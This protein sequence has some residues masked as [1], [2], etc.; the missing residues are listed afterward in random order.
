MDE[1]RLVDLAARRHMVLSLAELRELG[2]GVNGVSRRTGSGRLRRLHRGVYA[3][4]PGPLTERGRWRAA[5]LASSPGAVLSHDD[6]G[7]LWGVLRSR[8]GRAH[9]S[10]ARVGPKDVRGVVLHR[11]SRLDEL[12]VTERDGIPVTSPART[13]V[14]LAG[15]LPEARLV[16]VLHEAEVQRLLDVP[17]ILGA[18]GRVP[19]RKG[20][21]SLRRALAIDDGGPLRSV[22][23]ERFADLIH[24]AGLPPPRRNVQID[25]G[26]RLVEV[27][28]LW[29][30][31]RLVAELDGEGAHRTVRAF[32][33]DRRRDIE[34]ARAGY[35]V[36]RITWRRLKDDPSGV[37]ADIDDLI[38]R[39]MSA[40]S[41]FR[42]PQR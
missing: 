4:A 2:L 39:P 23:E 26:R 37:I 36:I 38:R 35:V 27:D 42:S 5:V 14:D 7:A 8:G 25:V 21:G 29:A 24:E 34:L 13:I 3:V 6:A 33:G 15:R 1:R 41:P 32:E 31:A 11:V 10:T 12:D 40:V 28:A 19:N 9:V 22:L 18:L 17:A 20:A 16:R 30:A